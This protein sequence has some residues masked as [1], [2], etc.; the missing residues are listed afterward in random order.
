MEGSGGVLVGGVEAAGCVGFSAGHAEGASDEE[1]TPEAVGLPSP[2]GKRYRHVT[3][4]RYFYD[5]NYLTN[6]S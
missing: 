2:E 3:S 4:S 1:L 5:P 6:R